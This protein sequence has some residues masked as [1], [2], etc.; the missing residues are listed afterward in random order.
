MPA[1]CQA[2]QIAVLHAL[3]RGQPGYLLFKYMIL[4]RKLGLD[5]QGASY[6]FLYVID[7][8]YSS[9]IG[10]AINKEVV[11]QFLAA[12]PTPITSLLSLEPSL[13]YLMIYDHYMQ[14][15][16]RIKIYLIDTVEKQLRFYSIG[17]QLYWNNAYN[18]HKHEGL[19]NI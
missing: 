17:P 16:S 18:C 6:L 15:Q 8:V 1:N 11:F 9:M 5:N 4:L 14:Q 19:L 10:Q 3:V 12:F 7:G 13:I 2:S